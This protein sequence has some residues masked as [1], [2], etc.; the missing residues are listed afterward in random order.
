MPTLSQAATV[1][2][3]YGDVGAFQKT[4]GVANQIRYTADALRCVTGTA[5][6]IAQVEQA[7]GHAAALDWL[8]FQI[9]DLS[10]YFGG[11]KITVG[12]IDQLTQI[13]AQECRGQKVTALMLFFRRVKT[14]R[15]GQFYGSVDP[16]RIMDY[17]RQFRADLADII[18]QDERRRAAEHAEEI[19]QA[20]TPFDEIQ[21]RMNEGQYPNLKG[22]LNGD[23]NLLCDK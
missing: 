8:T 14:G 23:Y 4:F 21:R 19:K 9:A 17:Y 7:Y 3:R 13:M 5:P 20:A 10:E 22:Y 15:Y 2:N 1:I 6:T 12:Q 18:E 16:M 11:G